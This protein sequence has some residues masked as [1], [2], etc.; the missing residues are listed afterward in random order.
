MV[1]PTCMLGLWRSR[2]FKGQSV[3]HCTHMG[4]THNM[5]GC[6]VEKFATCPK[7]FGFHTRKYIL[8]KQAPEDIY[9]SSFPTHMGNVADRLEGS[10]PEKDKPAYLRGRSCHASCRCP[11]PAVF[12]LSLFLFF[13][14]PRLRSKWIS[15][16][17]LLVNI[18]GP[19]F[20]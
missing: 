10:A 3:T 16:E 9:A 5:H 19:N 8:S 4:H 7:Q 12:S 13:L 17:I 2:L 11:N 6:T 1:F 14:Y 20:Y 18:V 15:S